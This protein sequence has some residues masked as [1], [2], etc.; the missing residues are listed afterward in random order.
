M[1][2]NE[3][4][5]F[6]SLVCNFDSPSLSRDYKELCSEHYTNC[7]IRDDQTVERGRLSKCVEQAK[8]K[9]KNWN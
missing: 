2:I 3:F 6:V 5:V 1:T 4:I 8:D 9:S 7:A